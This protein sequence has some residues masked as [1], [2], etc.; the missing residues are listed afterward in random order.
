MLIVEVS[1]QY[2]LFISMACSLQNQLFISS[3]LFLSNVFYEGVLQN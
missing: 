3:Q 1:L 2:Q